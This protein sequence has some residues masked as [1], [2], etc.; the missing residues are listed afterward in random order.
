LG[1]VPDGYPRPVLTLPPYW[2]AH[3]IPYKHAS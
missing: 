2:I 3:Q 1:R